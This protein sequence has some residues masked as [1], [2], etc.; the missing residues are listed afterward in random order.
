MSY[1]SIFL[2]A[3]FAIPVSAVFIEFDN[4]LSDAVQDDSPLQLQ[5]VALFLD[6]KFNT[7]DPNNGLQVTVW[8]NVTGS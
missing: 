6:A 4:C 1:L 7:T 3:L 8:G 2:M 5:F